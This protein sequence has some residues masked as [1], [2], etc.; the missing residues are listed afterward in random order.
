MKINTIQQAAPGAAID[1]PTGF[2]TKQIFS[3]RMAWSLR[4]TDNLLKARKVPFCK[5]GKMCR[6]PWPEARDHL[7]R[8]YR[9][10]AVNK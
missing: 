4:T 5:V 8:N 6:I 1:S 9:I 2:I 7:L 10:N 3:E